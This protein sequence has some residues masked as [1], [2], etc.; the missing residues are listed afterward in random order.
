MKIA[1]KVTT[2]DLPQICPLLS[3]KTNPRYGS[4][5]R[6]VVEVAGVRFGAGLPVVIAGAGEV[7]SWDQTI[8]L[9]RT[10]KARALLKQG[11]SASL[12]V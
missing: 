11:M 5:S 9:A 12:C 3:R 1:G 4:D 6:R 8:E 7:E 10:V 2:D